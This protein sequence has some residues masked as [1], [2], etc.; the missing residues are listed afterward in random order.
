M[1]I[2]GIQAY[3]L[4]VQFQRPQV[5]SQSAYRKVSIC[6]VRIDTDEG[7]YGV[8]ESLARFGAQA[9][10]AL[11]EGLLAPTLIG[12]DPLSVTKHWDTMRNTLNGRSGGIL[13]EAIAGI[14]IAL[15]DIRGKALNAPI[16]MLLGGKVRDRVPVYAS[17]IMVDS[18]IHAAADRII[19]AG[20]RNLKLKCGGDIDAEIARI[21]KLRKYIGPE[22]GIMVD[23]NYIFSEY[24]ALRFAELAAEHHILWFEEPIQPENR[25]GYCRLSRKS[26]I[27][28]AAGESEFTAHDC[29]DLFVEG[30]VQFI[31]PD[32]SRCGGITECQRV[33]VAADAFGIQ[34]APHVGFSGV[35]CVAASLHLAAAS[36]N[37]AFQECM[38][39]PNA[40]REELAVNPYGL[41]TQVQDGTVAIPEGP[42]LGIEIDW[43][44]VE[45]LW[46]R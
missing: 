46:D 6:L 14:D 35:A 43:N 27:A 15:W 34:Y 23:A 25:R 31:Q 5:T 12:Q 26:P 38:I 9:Y 44:A 11:I 3:P 24:Q 2:T 41:Y 22:Y 39:T 18:D 28:L 30:A 4:S 17:S 37:L 40:L 21:A 7:I 16:W 29:T 33:A 42:G 36:R 10:A 13:F 1:K 45:R 8:G 32:I 20:F 19:A